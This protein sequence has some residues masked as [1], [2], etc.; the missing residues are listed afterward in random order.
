MRIGGILNKGS[1]S[2]GQWTDIILSMGITEEEDE[3][4]AEVNAY[5]Q[6]D[7]ATGRYD[8]T[9]TE[10]TRVGGSVFIGSYRSLDLAAFLHHVNTAVKWDDP[11]HVQ[12]FVK[13]DND[14]QFKIV[15]GVQAYDHRFED[16]D[17]LLG[18]AEYLVEAL[19][20]GGTAEDVKQDA[21]KWLAEYTQFKERLASGYYEKDF[22]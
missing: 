7:Q 4:I 16:R 11:E 20:D 21:I 18:D 22:G 8:I 3:R 6:S 2:M 15:H 1:K 9:L 17:H 5:F 19:R 12:V 10:E 13:L 14:E